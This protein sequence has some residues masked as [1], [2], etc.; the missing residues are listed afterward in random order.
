MG[1]GIFGGGE[2]SSSTSTTQNTTNVT[3]KNI[4]A[5]EGSVVAMEGGNIELLDAGAINSAFGFAD[6][7]ASAYAD[8]TRQI[9]AG[10]G[11][12]LQQFGAST[13]RLAS[14]FMSGTESLVKDVI[15]VTE[16]STQNAMVRVADLAQENA[17]D[18]RTFAIQQ[19]QSESGRLADLVKVGIVAIAVVMGARLFASKQAA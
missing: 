8:A 16:R 1:W 4:G 13:E 2:D 19:S 15:G 14:S 3:N 6:R 17:A 11:S 12:S 18:L 9:V 10:Y 5:S 7:N